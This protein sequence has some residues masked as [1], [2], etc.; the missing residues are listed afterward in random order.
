MRRILLDCFL[1]LA[2]AAAGCAG[3]KRLAMVQK[4]EITAQ[5][6]AGSLDDV[7]AHLISRDTASVPQVVEVSDLQG[8]SIVMNAVKDEESGEMVA[9]EQLDEIVVVARFRHVAER[10]GEVDLVF[11]LSVP[12]ELQ[13]KRWQVRFTPHYHVLEDTL[14]TEQIFI[15]GERFRRVQNWEHM[16]YNN[17][18]RKIVPQHIAD[19]IYTRNRLM[20]RFLARAGKGTLPMA[21]GG[22]SPM[23]G[24]VAEDTAML[25]IP[26]RAYDLEK[27]AARHYR[28]RLMEKI[29][30]NMADARRDI[31]N[32]FV[33]D[34]FPGGGVR[35][36]SVVYDRSIGGIRYHYVQNIKTGPGLKKVEMVMHGEVYT[37]GRK[38]CSL[39]ATEP[40]TF[41]IS[42][43]SAFTDNTERYL[44]KVVYRDLH[45]STSY[46]IDFR[47]GMWNI[48]PKFS[49]NGKELASI[50]R[51]IVQI[52]E[53]EDY[54]MDSILIS[55]SGS[56]DGKLHV[57]ERI[58]ERRGDAIRRYVADC[59]E[60]LGDSLK[61]SVWE[62]NADESYREEDKG[63]EGFDVGNIRIVSV[64]EDWDA[65][66]GFIERDTVLRDKGD[67]LALFAIGDLDA[68]EDALRRREGF[69]YVQENLYP[70]LR[71][72]RFDFKLHRK[73]MLKD[74]V[75]TTELDTVYMKGVE[76]LRERDYK[77]AVTLLRPYDCFN[78]AV[79][80][81][82]MDYNQSA[83]DVL[84]RLPRDARR[85]Y[86]L[87]VVYS[88][89]GDERMAVQYFMNSVEQD[90]AMR[91][92][93]N[94]DPEISSLI[95]RY[96]IFTNQ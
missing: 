71:R 66:Y 88:R 15:T 19:S 57:N 68:R 38:L 78:T 45:L 70:K 65:L 12:L 34:P 95:K 4:E 13:Q 59:V 14:R 51:N 64:P 77:L 52:M 39:V 91:M 18:L 84:Q 11:E 17:Y 69:G 25:I 16:M 31:Y 1:L 53:N 58:S 7:D 75:H 79:A 82:S 80:Y 56:P 41:Y 22:K 81:V 30:V 2:L 67:L 47:K 8:H 9:L 89:L 44:K 83:L 72:V 92:R 36:D 46:N 26:Q 50:R 6:A 3:G 48:D 24:A 21:G 93:G 49:L 76:A 29:N 63:N 85:D 23:S 40:I 10:N 43:M 90:D 55:A 60:F 73:G 74:T 62:I 87:A 32:R 42:S 86:M 5:V 33:V 27:E 28:R 96:G 54:Q 20:E 94:L 37:N 61:K 35:L